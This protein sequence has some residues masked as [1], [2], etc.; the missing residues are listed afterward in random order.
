MKNLDNLN[1]A[2]LAEYME[3][4]ELAAEPVAAEPSANESDEASSDQEEQSAGKKRLQQAQNISADNLMEEILARTRQ[5]RKTS[6]TDAFRVPNDAF[7]DAD[8]EPAPGAYAEPEEVSLDDAF[9]DDAV[10]NRVS[11]DYDGETVEDDTEYEL[12]DDSPEYANDSYESTEGSEYVPYSASEPEY[13]DYDPDS[14]KDDH[15]SYSLPE[16]FEETIKDKILQYQQR[17][18]N[19]FISDDE[20]PDGDEEDEE[21]DEETPPMWKQR[22][23][24]RSRREETSY[25]Y[26]STTNDSGEEYNITPEEEEELNQQEQRQTE[27]QK[28][29]D[30]L[31]MGVAA[32]QRQHETDFHSVTATSFERGINQPQPDYVGM[33][34]AAMNAIFIDQTPKPPAEETVTDKMYSDME[35]VLVSMHEELTHESFQKHVRKYSN[36]A[37]FK[38]PNFTRDEK[39]GVGWFPIIFFGIVILGF[40]VYAGL[41]TNSYYWEALK[42]GTTVPTLQAFFRALTESDSYSISLL[43]LD[44]RYF[45]TGFGVVFGIAALIGVFIWLDTSQNKSSRV[46]HEH[47]EKH[48]ATMAELKR[49]KHDYMETDSVYRDPVVSSP[50]NEKGES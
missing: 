45:F 21:E 22:I 17:N 20:L 43:P 31:R 41:I 48:I 38:E 14:V 7:A 49:Y 29:I 39:D 50:D 40:G 15:Y 23:H 3:N 25:E 2:D 24:Y 10:F 46:G 37:K 5:M 44:T 13:G 27:Q 19:A 35:G 4:A 33:K 16:N 11:Y 28:Y 9:P 47:G 8:N 30:M 12:D 18:M 36:E 42:G 26:Q 1:D 6:E 34:D 32:Y